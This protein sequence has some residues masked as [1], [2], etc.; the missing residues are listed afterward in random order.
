[1]LNKSTSDTSYLGLLIAR[2][3]KEQL[4]A[5][6]LY[7]WT[8]VVY[9]AGLYKPEGFPPDYERE[10]ESDSYVQVHDIC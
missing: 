8:W 6:E 7:K 3:E 2:K 10:Y 9:L 5:I 1:M 4:E